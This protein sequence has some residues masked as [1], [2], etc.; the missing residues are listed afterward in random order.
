MNSRVVRL[1]EGL[2]H[3]GRLSQ[4]AMDRAIAALQGC[5]AWLARR[6]R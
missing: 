5:A 3:T 1:G 6:L 2:H 4:T